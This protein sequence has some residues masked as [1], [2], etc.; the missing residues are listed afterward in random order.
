MIVLCLENSLCIKETTS[1]VHEFTPVFKEVHVAR[2]LIVCV[3][4]VLLFLTIVL[5]V[6]LRFTYSNY[7]FLVSSNV[8]CPGVSMS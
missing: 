2:S 6:L 1:G 4:F 3:V 8:S 7:L 5:S